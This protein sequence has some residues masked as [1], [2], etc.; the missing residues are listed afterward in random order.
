MPARNAAATVVDALNSLRDQAHLAEIIVIDDG[1]TDDTAARAA[2]LGDARIRILP[3]P[4]NGISAALNTGFFAARH[5]LIAR[6]DADDTYLP[7]RL[8]SQVEW[9]SRHPDHVAVSGGFLSLDGRGRT[10]AR[11]AAEGPAREV[12]RDLRSGQVVTT[13]CTWLIRRETL[14][15]TGGA[16]PWFVTAEDIDLQ[17]RLAFLGSVWH[18]PQ[19]V[20]GYRLHD[21]SI[22]HGRRATQLAF[23]DKAARSFADERAQTGSDALDQGHPPELPD[24]PDDGSRLN[25][26]A[27][28]M[29]GHL[30]SQAWRDHTAGFRLTGLRLMLRALAQEPKASNL[31]KG[32]TIMLIKSFG[33]KSPKK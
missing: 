15:Q 18:L 13:L 6:C 7:G 22:T 14:L 5:P 19:P 10:L 2:A 31:W 16:R 3:G 30:V 27:R 9:L 11:L 20:Y 33:P 25:S 8:E 28:Q 17:F 23:Y 12:T 32:L 4:R 26:A 1:S 29:A 24:L 21:N